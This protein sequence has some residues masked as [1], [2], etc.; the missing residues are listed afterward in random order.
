MLIA[1]WES[2]FFVCRTDGAYPPP[3][4]TPTPF[5]F[6]SA[7]SGYAV[8]ISHQFELLTISLIKNT[9]WRRHRLRAAMA[10]EFF[11]WI[12]GSVQEGSWCCTEQQQHCSRAFWSLV[13]RTALDVS[14]LGAERTD[15]EGA[16]HWSLF[17]AAQRGCAL[18][19]IIVL[20]PHHLWGVGG[21]SP[22][23]C[24]R[25]VSVPHSS[26]REFSSD[27][28]IGRDFH[29]S[30]LC[31]VCAACLVGAKGFGPVRL[32]CL[33]LSPAAVWVEGKRQGWINWLSCPSNPASHHFL[34]LLP[35]LKPVESYLNEIQGFSSRIPVIFT[36]NLILVFEMP[37]R[38]FKWTAEQS[39]KHQVGWKL[40]VIVNNGV[41][42]KTPA[43]AEARDAGH[44]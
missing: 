4:P 36:R 28:A 14:A 21:A 32:V 17:S 2:P 26:C 9:A 8:H 13:C 42:K 29:C 25:S 19:S 15:D 22:R 34:F 5:T 1:Q 23:G 31:C 41:K 30:F 37:V 16:T 40:Q 10:S 44:D 3:T 6:H 38:F 11:L 18:K 43:S 33:C 35:P 12:K 20:H 39:N 7:E 24:V 27:S